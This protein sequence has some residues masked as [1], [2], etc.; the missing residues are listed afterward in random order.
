VRFATIGEQRMGI[1]ATLVR[2]SLCVNI[3]VLVPVCISLLRKAAWCD[4][5]YG[6][7]SPARGILASIYL[8]I[9]LLSIALLAH[10]YAG[11]IMALLTVQVLY[12]V[13]TP[14]TVGTFANPVVLSNLAIALLHA[15]TLVSTVR[16][17]AALV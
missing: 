2:L 6:P 5:A 7:S 17:A 16:A 11:A 9:L 14:F 10:P 13:T 15:F 8:A 12:K 1:T 4:S 3:V